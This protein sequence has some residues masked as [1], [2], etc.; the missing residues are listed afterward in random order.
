MAVTG[1]KADFMAF[2][3]H[4]LRNLRGKENTL[5]HDGTKTLDEIIDNYSDGGTHRN[6]FDNVATTITALG[7]TTSE[8]LDLK[9]FLLNGLVSK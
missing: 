2:K 8:K 6:H 7:L 3:T 9:D 5:G 4:G 1:S